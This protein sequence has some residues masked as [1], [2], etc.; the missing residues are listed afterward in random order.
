MHPADLITI[1]LKFSAAHRLIHHQGKCHNLHGH[2][3]RVK[4]TVASTVPDLGPSG[5][6]ADFALIKEI[7]GG[8]IDKNWD[9]KTILNAQDPMVWERESLTDPGTPISLTVAVARYG[10]MPFILSEEPTAENLARHLRRKDWF[11]NYPD[12]RT[13]TKIRRVTVFETD[14]CSATSENLP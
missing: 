3:Y 10:H 9:H 1:R 6:V 4:V 5:M 11:A 14:N 2:N 7:I 13:T 8:W 12:L